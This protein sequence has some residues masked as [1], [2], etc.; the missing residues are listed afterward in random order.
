MNEQVGHLQ[1]EIEHKDA[2]INRL[3]QTIATL[4]AGLNVIAR[5]R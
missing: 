2:E 5:S 3:E 4:K 1:R